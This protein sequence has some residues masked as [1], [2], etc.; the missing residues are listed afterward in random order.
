MKKNL[1]NITA[2]K[3]MPESEYYVLYEPTYKILKKPKSQRRKADQW[4]LGAGC[5]RAD[6]KG[7]KQ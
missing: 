2:T 5:E 6:W 1:K 3:K 7:Q 4:F